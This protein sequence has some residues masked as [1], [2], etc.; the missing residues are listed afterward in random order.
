M[1]HLQ[2][3]VWHWQQ[4]QAGTKYEYVQK[5]AD[6][7]IF[8]LTKSTHNTA[9]NHVQSISN[10]NMLDVFKCLNNSWPQFWTGHSSLIK[11]LKK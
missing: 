2:R 5:E 10:E 7:F 4:L 8:L 1:Q 9:N 3:V 11:T 6:F